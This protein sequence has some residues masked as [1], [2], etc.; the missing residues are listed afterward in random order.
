MPDR[1]M[2]H[3]CLVHVDALQ[4]SYTVLFF[5]FLHNTFLSYLKDVAENGIMSILYNDLNFHI[6][7]FFFE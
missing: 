6:A 4:E 7:D 2:Q 3:F 5:D 1:S